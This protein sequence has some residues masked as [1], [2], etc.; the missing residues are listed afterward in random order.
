MERQDTGLWRK[1]QAVER[2]D[3]AMR[4]KDTSGTDRILLCG[5]NVTPGKDGI[6]LHGSESNLLGIDVAASL[7]GHRMSVE[8]RRHCIW[9]FTGRQ[10]GVSAAASVAHGRRNGPVCCCEA[11]ANNDGH[12]MSVWSKRHCK[13]SLNRVHDWC[14]SVQGVRYAVNMG[15][16]QTNVD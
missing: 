15:I 10:L 11:S 2:L 14:H 1:D 13:S 16:Q 4:G 8:S 9:D 5:G 6:L 7:D 12:R 3:P